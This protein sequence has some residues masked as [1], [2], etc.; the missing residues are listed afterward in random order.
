MRPERILTD[1][2]H[3]THTHELLTHAARRAQ[4]KP[5]YVAFALSRYQTRYALTDAALAER[6]GCDSLTLPRLSLCLA[7][8][9]GHWSEDLAQIAGTLGL[10]PQVLSAILTEGEKAFESAGWQPPT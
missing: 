6:L 9:K 8:R 5:A 4:D 7:P 1:A 2:A 10:D 3:I